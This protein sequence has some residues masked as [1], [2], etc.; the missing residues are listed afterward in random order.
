MIDQLVL[1]F[2]KEQRP[3]IVFGLYRSLF[4]NRWK[5]NVDKHLYLS[6]L[7]QE[8]SLRLVHEILQIRSLPA[9]LEKDL[10]Q[11]TE[12]NPF[13]MKELLI[14]LIKKKVLE[15]NEEEMQYQLLLQTIYQKI[16]Y[17]AMSFRKSS[18]LG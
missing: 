6:E 2:K 9:S 17:S 11:K 3:V 13:Y 10:L 18:V 12:G 4:Q 8:D 7:S 14:Y 5:C 16:E 1:R 15:W